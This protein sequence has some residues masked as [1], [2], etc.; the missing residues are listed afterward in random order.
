MGK[1]EMEGMMLSDAARALWAKSDRHK[2]GHWHPLIGHSLDVAASTLV[3]LKREP[4]STRKLFSGELEISEEAVLAWIPGLIGTHDIGKCIPGF[5]LQWQRDGQS[6]VRAHLEQQGFPW[7]ASDVEF[8]V[9]PHAIASQVFL[10]V[11]LRDAGFTKKTARLLAEALGAHHGFRASS[12]DVKFARSKMGSDLWQTSRDQLFKSILEATGAS[13]YSAP[14]ALDLSGEGFMRLA[15][16]TSVADW[17]GSNSSFFSY[18]GRITDVL[19]HDIVD[20]TAYFQEAVKQAERALNNIGWRGE[21]PKNLTFTAIFPFK[22]RPLQQIVMDL[23]EGVTGPVLLLVEAPMGEGKTEAA[24]FGHHLLQHQV[25]HRGVYIALPTQA[26]SNAMFDRV[27]TFLE[28]LGFQDPPDIQLVHGAAILDEKF[29][30]IKLDVG[31]WESA[32]QEQQGV[33]AS[34]WFTPKKQA[35]LSPHGVGTVDQTLLGVLN[36][37]HH[38]VRLFGLANRTI[39]FD[40]VHAYELYT[41]SLIERLVTWLQALGSSVIL[42]SATLPSEVRARLIRAFGSDETGTDV[43]YPRVTRV[44]GSTAT[45]AALEAR[46]LQFKLGEAPL[47]PVELARFLFDQYLLG[48]AVGCVVNTVQ[49]AQDVYA[50]LQRLLASEFDP[51]KHVLLHARFPANQRLEIEEHLKKLI[52]EKHN[53]L[54]N[55]IVV[56]T[57]VIEQSLDVDFDVLVS[58]LAPIDLLLQRAG[59]LHRHNDPLSFQRPRPD[60]HSIA[61]LYVSGLQPGLSMPDISSFYWDWVYAPAVLLRT[62]AVL[63]HRFQLCVPE[64]LNDHPK[65]KAAS[66][67]EQVYSSSQLSGEFSEGFENALTNAQEKLEEE[68]E[69]E[70]KMAQAQLL[71]KP[72]L[73]FDSLENDEQLVDDDDPEVSQRLRAVT[74]LGDPSITLIPLYRQGQDFFLEPTFETRINLKQKPN[75]EMAKTL[76]RRAVSLSNKTVF[77]HFA[78][79]KAPEGW[80]ESALLKHA[81]V[82]PLETNQYVVR[83]GFKIVLD[84]TQGVMYDRS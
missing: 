42:L 40:E 65:T 13:N 66:L 51:K 17:L 64:D 45:T 27:R 38:F 80:R 32:L 83:D 19:T 58:D 11:A 5:Q 25:G 74:R 36:V 8:G 35:L 28:K 68:K 37:G 12:K 67:L 39:V 46:S 47:E 50:E 77:F 60:A 34:E 61:R 76:L 22:P 10:E 24:L 3:L 48:G 59:R 82:L 43:P 75:L 4:E 6:V 23:L 7:V 16:L 72:E 44:L 18:R 63:R 1:S 26:T 54:R 71:P 31:D 20:S 79:Q 69:S 2:K 55:V 9:P 29:N 21:Q 15:G 52:G 70:R 49:R 57:Q 30:D 81:R 53:E 41:S 78:Y 14:T 56:A 62:W 84:R 33:M 73:L